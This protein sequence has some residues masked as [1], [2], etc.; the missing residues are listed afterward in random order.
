MIIQ[1]AQ[2][3]PSPKHCL[4]TRSSK[5]NG[6]STKIIKSFISLCPDINDQGIHLKQ[7]RKGMLSS[8]WCVLLFGKH[9]FWVPLAHCFLTFFLDHGLFK[10][11]DFG[12]LWTPHPPPKNAY[13]TCLSFH[14]FREHLETSPWVTAW[15]W[16]KNL[17]LNGFKAAQ[18]TSSQLPEECSLLC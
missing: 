8:R 7:A 3:S 6:Q 13:R 15:A 11:D 12:K 18:Q 1:P 4:K 10:K 2:W 14:G 9:L 17:H 5:Y 16:S